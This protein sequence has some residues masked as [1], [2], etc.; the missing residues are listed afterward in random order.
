MALRADP[1]AGAA[2]AVAAIE[3]RCGG[4]RYPGPSQESGTDWHGE[5]RDCDFTGLGTLR[6]DS[7]KKETSSCGHF[8]DVKQC[9]GYLS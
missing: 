9:G 8:I 4:G 7:E 6:V 2:E 3:K 5:H 1:L